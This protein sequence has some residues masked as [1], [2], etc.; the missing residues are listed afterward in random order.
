MG[1]PGKCVA[2]GKKFQTKNKGYKRFSLKSQ[3][4]PSFG[5]DVAAALSQALPDMIDKFPDEGHVCD[6]CFRLLRTTLRQREQL[7]KTEIEWEM[8]LRSGPQGKHMPKSR[9]RGKTR[10]NES[11]TSKRKLEE[12]QNTMNNPQ[13]SNSR[14]ERRRKRMK[15][16]PTVAVLCK[17]GGHKN[18]MKKSIA[19][20]MQYRYHKAFSIIIA[21]SERAKKAF[22]GVMEKEIRKEAFYFCKTAEKLSQETAIK[23]F[24][25]K[26]KLKKMELEMPTFYSACHAAMDTRKGTVMADSRT[27]PSSRKRLIRPRLGLMMTL[28]LYARR[29]RKFGFVMNILS[30]LFHRYGSHEKMLKILRHLGVCHRNSQPLIRKVDGMKAEE[31]EKLLAWAVKNLAEVKSRD[32]VAP[33]SSH[34]GKVAKA[35]LPPTD[36]H[37]SDDSDSDDVESDNENTMVNDDDDDGEDDDDDDDDSSLLNLLS[38]D[39][40]DSGED[41]NDGGDGSEEDEEEDGGERGVDEIEGEVR[42]EQ[43]EVEGW[44]DFIEGEEVEIQT[45]VNISKALKEMT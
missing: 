26:K 37:H 20:L 29:E 43:V 28:P 31:C 4:G 34:K 24:S 35:Q 21:E 33:K 30:L 18:Y 25:W 10:K 13:D 7:L 16:E 3:L 36:S 32:G 2:C 6:S 12:V 38:S 14:S 17:N 39:A 40:S 11:R 9:V 42:E 8:R 27:S 1:K 22:I 23:N 5:V 44:V 45:L 19:Y 41:E 15:L